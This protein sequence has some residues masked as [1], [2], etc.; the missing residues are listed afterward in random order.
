LPLSQSGERKKKAERRIERA[1][2]QGCGYGG[3]REKKQNLKGGGGGRKGKEDN[4]R[5]K[6]DAFPGGG[7]ENESTIR[8]E[9]TKTSVGEIEILGGGLGEQTG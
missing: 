9:K 6:T 5:K 2:N 7:S 4:R 1:G 8:Q 3:S